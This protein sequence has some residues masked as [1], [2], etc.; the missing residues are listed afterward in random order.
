[1]TPTC[2]MC[3]ATETG[4][5]VECDP[6][7]AVMRCA[8]CKRNPCACEYDDDFCPYCDGNPCDCEPEEDYDDRE[9]RW[10]DDLFDGVGVTSPGRWFLADWTRDLS[11]GVGVLDVIA[12]KQT[13]H[14]VGLGGYPW[15]KRANK[16]RV[17]QLRRKSWPEGRTAECPE[18]KGEACPDD[19]AWVPF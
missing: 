8:D 6:E 4:A 1:M 7:R 2:S 12:R 19:C 9:R 17:M 16:R 15:Q 10:S 3:G 18:H 11:G 5:H 14:G 13:K